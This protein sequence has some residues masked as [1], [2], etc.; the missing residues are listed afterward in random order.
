MKNTIT[1]LVADD[2]HIFVL[3][4]GYTL[5]IQR[6]DAAIEFSGR[7]SRQSESAFNDS[8]MIQ[9]LASQT[10]DAQTYPEFWR[11]LNQFEPCRVL[12][13]DAFGRPYETELW[14]IPI[15]DADKYQ[16]W[17][18]WELSHYH[19]E[20]C[21]QMIWRWVPGDYHP[22]YYMRHSTVLK[23][24]QVARSWVEH[25]Q[26]PPI[27]GVAVVSEIEWQRRFNSSG[28]NPPS[29]NKFS[30]LRSTQ[31]SLLIPPILRDL[32]RRVG[33]YLALFVDR[34]RRYT[35]DTA[36]YLRGEL[37]HRLN[38]AGLSDRPL[39]QWAQLMDYPQLQ[40]CLGLLDRFYQKLNSA[41]KGLGQSPLV[42]DWVIFEENH[43]GGWWNGLGLG[44]IMP[45]V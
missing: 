11:C 3:I 40:R 22:D 43:Y 41:F 35:P 36:N 26:I 32:E 42:L 20:S 6:V 4:D 37:L 10:L 25:Q 9:L 24:V 8:W 12:T 13:Y 14:S 28:A 45:A 30:A 1:E 5:V 15:A 44:W 23:I 31:I 18:L 38:L 29:N 27:A 17:S 16:D 19:A 33:D 7:H 34:A 2:W 21:D 39:E